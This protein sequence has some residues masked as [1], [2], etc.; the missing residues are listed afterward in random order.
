AAAKKNGLAL[1]FAA[2]SAPPAAETEESE[3]EAKPPG[4]GNL[5][6]GT[7]APPPVR[8][9]PRIGMSAET[10]KAFAADLVGKFGDE[11]KSALRDAK[12]KKSIHDHKTALRS[13]AESGVEVA[14][15]AHDTLLYAYLLEPTVANQTLPQVV[16]RRLNL[17]LTGGLAQSADM[18]AR[19]A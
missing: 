10:G 6:A 18:T 8:C 16:L 15:V 17:Q 7:P 3:G 14:G 2:A 5:F 11:L 13:C 19:L 9:D 1:A 12:V 4:S